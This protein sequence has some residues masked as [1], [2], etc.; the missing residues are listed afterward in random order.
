MK[1]IFTIGHSTRR[2]EEFMEILKEYGIEQI[3]DIRTIPKSRHNPQFNEGNLSKALSSIGIKYFHLEKLGG[4]RHSGKDSK[5]LG[6]KNSSFRGFADYMQTEDFSEG[7][8]ELVEISKNAKTAIMCAE[9]V[10]W[11]CHRS[12]IGDALSIRKINVTDI[13]SKSNSREHKLTSFAKVR[14][15]NITYP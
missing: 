6:W 11:K 10:P 5:N 15:K 7:L 12:L 14:G 4:L 8:K 9:A 3:A 1:E 13:F 2:I